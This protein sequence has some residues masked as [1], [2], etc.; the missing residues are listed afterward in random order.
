MTIRQGV[1][2]AAGDEP[3]VERDGGPWRS[4]ALRQPDFD[5]TVAAEAKIRIGRAKRLHT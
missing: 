2:V 4:G 3:A 5:R 1:P